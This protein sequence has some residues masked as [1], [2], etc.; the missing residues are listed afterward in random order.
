MYIYKQLKRWCFVV[1]LYIFLL[2][3]TYLI[4][5]DKISLIKDLERLHDTL[6]LVFCDLYLNQRVRQSR[7]AAE[8]DGAYPCCRKPGEPHQINQ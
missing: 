8:T 7:A 5:S 2:F 1:F 6:L 3:S 4:G